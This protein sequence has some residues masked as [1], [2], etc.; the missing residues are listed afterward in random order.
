[1]KVRYVLLVAAAAM[2]VLA[3]AAILGAKEKEGPKVMNVSGVLAAADGGSIA[4][5]V[6]KGEKGETETKTIAVDGNTKVLIETDQMESVPG[7]GGK[8]HEKAKI[9]EGKVDDL[10][11][12]VGRKVTVGYIADGA[13]AVKILVQRAA[14]PKGGKEGDKDGGKEGGP[15]APKPP[16]AGGEGDR[17][18]G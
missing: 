10:K 8:M 14:P 9:V 5:L 17:K 12:L 6:K 16:R 18:P 3:P 15:R 1:M 13:K 11:T 7:E 2:L 4:V